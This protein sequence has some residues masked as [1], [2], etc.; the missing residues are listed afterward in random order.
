VVVA[1][2]VGAAAVAA[3]DTVG[4]RAVRQF[5]ARLSRDV[6]YAVASAPGILYRLDGRAPDP[7]VS[8]DVLADRIRSSIGP[9][10]KRLDLPHV[11]V[12]VEDHI[13]TLSGN[14]GSPEEADRIEHAVLA[15]SGVDDVESHLHVGLSGGDTRPSRGRAAPQPPSTAMRA[16]TAAATEAGASEP[17]LAVHAVLCRF[18]DTIPAGER[19]HVMVHLPQD[20]KDL[21]GPTRYGRQREHIRTLEQLT[22]RVGSDDGIAPEWAEDLSRRVITTLREIAADEAADVE[23][24]LPAGLR[25]V[26][27]SAA[28][29]SSA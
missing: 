20:V 12:M 26:W 5:A 11:H 10:L 23:A 15:L 21:V 28:D 29:A 2:A 7:D 1:G 14:V 27:R 3:P 4:G 22:A 9:L 18:I 13:A 24:V 16:L 19:A 17:R 25:E 8:D 6:R